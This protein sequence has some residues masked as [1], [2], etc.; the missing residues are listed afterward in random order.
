MRQIPLSIIIP[1]FNE[2]KYLSKL[3]TSIKKQTI[4]P[5]EII[6]VDAFSR[7]KTVVYAKKFGC[8]ILFN[9]TRVAGSRNKG[10]QIATQPL[11]LFLDADVTLPATFLEKTVREF[12]D[13]KL[14]IAACFV[15]PLSNSK[16]DYFMHEFA[17]YYIRIINTIYPHG[18]GYCIFATKKIHKKIQGFD[19][20]LIMAEDHDYVKRASLFGSF[21]YVRSQ[22]IFISV[23]RLVKEGRMRFAFKYVTVEIYRLFF[24]KIRKP[25]FKYEFGEHI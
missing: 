15:K 8:K 25:L 13:K 10:A 19:E 17:N 20:S 2:E 23:R 9:N 11:L 12:Q 16:I 14:A 1:T 7:D 6:V 24:D 3:L 21:D 22:K 18:A 5:K 4:Q